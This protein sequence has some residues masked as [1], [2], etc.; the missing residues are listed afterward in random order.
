MLYTIGDLHGQSRLL[1]NFTIEPKSTIIC[2]G[3][4]GANFYLNHYDSTFKQNLK[5]Y[6]C[7]FFVVR[8]NHEIR[9]SRMM[10][11]FPDRWEKIEY[12]GNGAYREKEYPYIVYALDEAAIYEFEGL[13]TLVMGGAY[14]IDKD[15]RLLRDW[16]WFPDEQM[17]E[18]EMAAATNL[19]EEN[20]WNVDLVLT[21]TAPSA[22][23]P[24]DS[25]MSV[26]KDVDRSMEIFFDRIE[27]QL[28]YKLW[29]FG[30]YH[31]FKIMRS[32]EGKILIMHSAGG[33][34]IDIK[35]F[36]EQW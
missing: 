31:I 21:H 22:F 2:L 36:L 8:G 32:V 15:I 20:N 34:K 13:K 11:D 4:F 9:P 18:E 29:C 3:D 30:H 19:L 5:K 27:R 33:E 25:F 1:D 12:C 16:P 10:N 24:V 26:R 7:T 28:N 14:S 17:S 23:E 35:K 6:D